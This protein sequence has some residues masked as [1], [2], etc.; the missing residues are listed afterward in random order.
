M[1]LTDILMCIHVSVVDTLI[2]ID[3]RFQILEKCVNYILYTLLN[4]SYNYIAEIIS[5]HL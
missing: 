3:M 2:K 1:I 4:K 5:F